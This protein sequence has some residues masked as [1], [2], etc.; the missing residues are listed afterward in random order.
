VLSASIRKRRRG[1]RPQYV[2]DHDEREVFGLRAF[3]TKHLD[4]DGNPVLRFY[5]LDDKARRVYH[6]DSIDKAEAISNFH[7][8]ELAQENGTLFTLPV[9]VDDDAAFRRAVRFFEDFVI[10]VDGTVV[11]ER[12]MPA[13]SVRAYLV[14]DPALAASETR[15][16]DLNRLRSLPQ[17]SSL[18]VKQCGDLYLRRKKDAITQKEWAKAKTWWGEFCRCVSPDTLVRD[19][20]FDAFD[21]Y[22]SWVTT[23]ENLASPHTGKRRT[24]NFRRNR[25]HM[26]RTILNFAGRCRRISPEELARLKWEW[27]EPLTSPK[28]P[29][30][31]KTKIRAE[32]FKAMLDAAKT[33]QDRCML[34][35]A[36]N[37]A[38]YN[39]DLA[40]LTWDCLDL[41][42]RT[43]VLFRGKRDADQY[44]GI[45]RVAV[46][47]PETVDALKEL[48]R[49]A[50]RKHVFVSPSA[51]P[52][53]PDTIYD[54]LKRLKT[55]AGITRGFT[56]R[57]LRD[58]A[59]TIAAR[60]A[61]QAQYKVLMGHKLQ[62]SDDDYIVKNPHF[63]ADACNAVHRHFFD[64]Q[65][66]DTDAG[67]TKKV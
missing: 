7:Q 3:K 5:S 31:K 36:L 55:N 30:R 20:D 14:T 42:A 48:R 10:D 44:E 59:T 57:N 8:W 35:L 16:P 33:A 2:R 32:E 15:L 49:Q 37:G 56:P 9:N 52:M 24:K 64:G 53:H 23:Q 50:C 6:G 34:L 54:H 19:L 4:A 11:A 12:L 46:L 45:V 27:A 25:F 61:P 40:E 62:G 41:D 22:G 60:N 66:H 39:Q 47:W 17:P 51:R 21:L 58:T 13:E 63:V 29:R 65:S 18:T 67:T 28:R 43:M 38:L 26:I 1:P